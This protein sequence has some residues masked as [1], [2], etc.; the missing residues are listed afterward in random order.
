MSLQI[1]QKLR[2][3]HFTK[4]E[5]KIYATGVYLVPMKIQIHGID[6][7]IWVADDFKNDAFDENGNLICPHIIS[8]ERERMYKNG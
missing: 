8:N 3:Y 1:E 2:N 6:Q 4:K 5:P 7:F